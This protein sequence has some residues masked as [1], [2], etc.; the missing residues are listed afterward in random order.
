MIFLLFSFPVS[1]GSDAD[2]V[3]QSAGFLRDSDYSV[4]LPIT[5]LTLDGELDVF[6]S[7]FVVV[8]MS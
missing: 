7:H 1:L 8:A 3:A 5:V 6:I 4:S 2:L